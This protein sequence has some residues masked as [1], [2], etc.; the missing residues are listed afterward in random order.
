[1]LVDDQHTK[2]FEIL[3]PGRRQSQSIA[4]TRACLVG[5]RKHVERQREIAG[6]ARHRSDDRK[7]DVARNGR[8]ARRRLPP[9]WY[10]TPGW[11]VSI[12]ATI[13]RWRAQRAADVRT[14]RERPEAGG[15]CGGGPAR[16]APG[17]A[18]KIPG[19]VG[20][21]IDF[22]VALPVA[23]LQ[24]Y[25]RLAENESARGLEANDCDGVL[26]RRKVLE[27]RN[28]PGRGQ[29]GNVEGFLYSHRDAEERPPLTP[30]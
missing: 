19:I 22:V 26:R 3:T 18:R 8:K 12:D 11:L 25:V 6:A 21:S 9:I 24:R 23:Q 14:D 27:L 28:A 30:G 2:T 17:G 13:M 16:R 29:P 20:G 1:M 4:Y 15:E 10:E 7:I 5:T